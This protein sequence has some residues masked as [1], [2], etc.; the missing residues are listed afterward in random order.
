[1]LLFNRGIIMFFGRD[2]ELQKLN[3][4]KSK[5]AASLVVIK[6]RRRIGKSTL[7]Q[8]FGETFDLFCEIQGLAP[9][10]EVTDRDQRINFSEQILTIFDIPALTFENW[11]D[12]FSIL[13][14]YTRTSKCLILLD[15]ISWMASNHPEFAGKLKIAWDTKFKKNQNLILVICGSVSSWIDDHILYDTDF[16]GRVSLSIQ[17]EELPLIDCNQFFRG[18]S[19]FISSMEKLKIFAVTGGVPKYLE[20]IDIKNSAE[21]NIKKMCFDASGILFK[22]FDIIFKDIFDKRAKHYKEIIRTIVHK[23]LSASEIAAATGRPVNRDL[24]KYLNDLVVSGFLQ[25]DYVYKFEGKKSRLSKYRIKDNYLRFYLRYIEPIKDKIEQGLFQ[26]K[27]IEQL[28]GWESIMGLQFENLVLNNLPIIVNKMGIDFN[29]IISAS[30]Y[31]QN[32]TKSNKG[33]CQIDLLIQAKFGTLYLCEIKFKK[34]IDKQ[35]VKEISKK[36]E[37]LK[38]PR[39][40][41]IRP[42]LIYEGNISDTLLYDDFFD[43]IICFG[44]LLT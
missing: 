1:M 2:N 24:S 33:A 26:F 13:A 40:T 44:D 6:G 41:S 38:R 3:D 10:K 18:K 19:D 27:A 39:N 5:Q 23:N 37:L 29:S 25:R 14:S 42:V 17:L 36:I 15:E 28:S 35:V 16:L 11:H 8:K 30:P 4:L 34:N 22:E 7:I 31:F 12:A 20:E 32:A 21:N 9:G 43:K